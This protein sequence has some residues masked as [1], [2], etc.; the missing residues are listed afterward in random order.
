MHRR[1]GSTLGKSCFWGSSFALHV[2]QLDF[3]F[4][5]G[6]HA[7]DNTL[8]R[9]LSC[10]SSTAP[11]YCSNAKLNNFAKFHAALTA[12][13][14]KNSNKSRCHNAKFA[15]A[16]F[17][18]NI[19]YASLWSVCSLH[20]S[21]PPEFYDREKIRGPGKSYFSDFFLFLIATNCR[22]NQC[23]A[24]LL[25]DFLCFAFSCSFYFCFW[26]SGGNLLYKVPVGG[27]TMNCK[28]KQN[29]QKCV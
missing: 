1:W 29:T 7:L 5:F 24:F 15:Y 20:M 27:I 3:Q 26:G 12:A 28:N 16:I 9:L 14:V 2:L 8:L 23:V 13:R 11:P 10:G 25:S 4:S 18:L 19:S 17:S 21:E 6:V 22:F